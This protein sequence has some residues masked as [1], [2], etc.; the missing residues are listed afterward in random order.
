VVLRDPGH[1]LTARLLG[2]KGE[3][4]GLEK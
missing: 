2:D 1:H 4:F 3:S